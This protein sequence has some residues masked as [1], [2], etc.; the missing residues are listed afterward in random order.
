MNV[1][2]GKYLKNE[3]RTRLEKHMGLQKLKRNSHQSTTRSSLF[4]W[5]KG[6]LNQDPKSPW[7]LHENFSFG[8]NFLNHCGCWLGDQESN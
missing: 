2:E 4:V 7:S 1:N 5:M 6:E 8:R 3:R